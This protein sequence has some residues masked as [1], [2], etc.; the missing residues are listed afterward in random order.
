MD[1]EWSG[2]GCT[3]DVVAI[4]MQRRLCVVY[5]ATKTIVT[6]VALRTTGLHSVLSKAQLVYNFMQLS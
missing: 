1:F 6:S 2:G 5:L 3:K 4:R